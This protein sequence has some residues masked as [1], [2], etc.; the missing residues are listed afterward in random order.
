[1]RKQLKIDGDMIPI[2]NENGFQCLGYQSKL[3]RSGE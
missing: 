2:I 3:F 1:V